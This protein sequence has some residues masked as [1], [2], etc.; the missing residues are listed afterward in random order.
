MTAPPDPT[1]SDASEA[2]LA[3]AWASPVDRLTV[4]EAPKGA[5]AAT[6]RGRKLSGPLQGFGQLWQKT[7]RV[8]LDDT[9]EPAEVIAH[10]KAHFPEFW[11]K[12]NTFYAPLAGIKPGEVALLKITAAGPVKL[13]SGVMVI[14]A[15]ETSFSLMT[16]EGHALAAW[17]T[18]S[19]ERDPATGVVI[20]Q[21]QAL[22]RPSD[23]INEVA[24]LLGA[25]GKNSHFWEQT[26]ENFARSL[27]S[28]ARCETSVVRVDSRRQWRHA[29][30]VIHN[31]N[32]RGTIWTVTHPRSWL[33]R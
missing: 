33:R 7:F 15:D 20:A 2:R 26:V 25:N 12:G 23:P 21:T 1:G 13:N 30:N 9:R 16:P 10:W 32:I 22:E 29:G 14:Y 17:I 27:G 6:V 11:P 5:I 19:A 31:A 4:D 28:D 3:A 24:Y 8:R 18:F